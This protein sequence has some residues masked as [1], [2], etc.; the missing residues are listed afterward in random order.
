MQVNTGWGV[1]VHKGDGLF[2]SV[3]QPRMFRYDF[4]STGA[5]FKDSPSFFIMTGTKWPLSEKLTLYP[6]ALIRLAKD[7][8]ISYDV[9]VVANMNGKLEAGLGYRGNESIG[10]R[11]GVQMTKV[12]YL[13][14]VYELPT[15]KIS[16]MTSQTH[17]LAL[18]MRIAKK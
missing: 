7:V 6:S 14:Y 11:L 4:G 16:M 12:F 9:N 17:E 2:F 5:A 18:R 8:P 10:M 15:S 13:G 1:K 3:S